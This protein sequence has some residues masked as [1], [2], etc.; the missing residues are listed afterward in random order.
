MCFQLPF[1]R[2]LEKPI[3]IVEVSFPSQ[4]WRHVVM[5]SVDKIKHVFQAPAVKEMA[6]TYELIRWFCQIQRRKVRSV[7]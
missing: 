4:V 7:L 5:N 6:G 3:S 1:S 2:A